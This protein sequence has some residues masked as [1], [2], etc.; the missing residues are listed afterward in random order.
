MRRSIGSLIVACALA[1]GGP[2]GQGSTQSSSSSIQSNA[3]SAPPALGPSWS[4]STTSAAATSTVLLD[5]N[6]R[7]W[8]SDG[9][10]ALRLVG[11]ATAQQQQA[12]KAAFAALGPFAQCPNR[13]EL[14]FVP[15]D[16]GQRWLVCLD[17]AGNPKQPYLDAVNALEALPR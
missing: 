14:V 2:A 5:S 3:P 9:S 10:T 4:S 11:L 7:V 12:V 8:R 16:A 15:A 13:G 6:G 1:C 17:E